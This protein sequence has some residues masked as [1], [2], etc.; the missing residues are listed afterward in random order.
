MV[1]RQTLRRLKLLGEVLH[2]RRDY[3]VIRAYTV[4]R[5]GDKVYNGKGR[6][7]GYVSNIFGP[8]SS[9]YV[10]VKPAAEAEVVEGEAL[11]VEKS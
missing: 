8:V 5:L 11:Y 10:A 4:P 7:V 3:L 9:P 2:S 6:E 1:S